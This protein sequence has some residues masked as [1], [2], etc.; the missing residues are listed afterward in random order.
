VDRSRPFDREGL[1]RH[2]AQFLT[3]LQ[4]A[5]ERVAGADN[6][7]GRHIDGFEAWLEARNLTRTNLFTVLVKVVS[8]LRQIA[9]DSPDDISPDLRD[10][11]RYV[12]AK[13][14]QR[15]RPRDAYSPFVAHQL[16]DAAGTTSPP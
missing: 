9:T 6:L 8:V 2:L 14:F 16:R 4:E 12:S 5:G 7:R 1:C 13:P 3:Y 11:L 10:R 15:S